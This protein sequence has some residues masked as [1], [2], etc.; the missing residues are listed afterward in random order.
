MNELYISVDIETTGPT[1]GKYSMFEIGAV[2]VDSPDYDFHAHVAPLN[3][4][5]NPEALAATGTSIETLRGRG[6]KPRV[7]MGQFARWIERPAN[8]HGWRPVFVANNAPFDWM[9]VAWYFEKFGIKN[10]FGH[11]ALDMKAYF[12]GMTGSTWEEATLKRMAEY[13]GVQFE[14]LPHRALEDAVI[15]GKIF[16]KLLHSQ[17]PKRP[18][19]K[20]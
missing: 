13:T 1:P 8:F 9:F 14:K 5:Y 11:S 12:M 3:N 20:P 4:A 19:R 15:Q 10:P 6:D 16:S 18:R 2:C 7:A 17:R